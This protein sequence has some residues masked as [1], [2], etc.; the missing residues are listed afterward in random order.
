MKKKAK[1]VVGAV[2]IV[3]VLAIAYRMVNQ[4]PSADLP[5]NEQMEQILTDGGCLACHSANPELPFYANL[6]GAKGLIEK[7]VKD[8]YAMFDVAPFMA[9]LRDGSQPN[10]RCN[11]DE[12]IAYRMSWPGRSVT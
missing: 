6:P 8:G 10:S 11:F 4:A 1:I 5:A 3:A 9:S 7:H 2:G 12:S